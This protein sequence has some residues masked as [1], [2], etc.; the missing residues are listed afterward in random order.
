MALAKVNPDV[1]ALATAA[2]RE[3]VFGQVLIQGNATAFEMRHI[4]DRGAPPGGLR[5]VSENEMRGLA[6]FTSAGA[7]RPL[8]SAP[9]L[10]TGWRM[11]AKDERALGAALNHLY[12]GGVADWHAAQCGNPPVTSYRDFTARQTG[13]YRITTFLNDA[14]AAR[15]M[16]ACCHI[17]FCLKRRL[18]TVDGEPCDG[19]SAKSAIP[20]LEPCAVL[21][22][23]ARK[24]ARWEQQGT[25]PDAEPVEP[26][27]GS[28]KAECNFD[29]P[30]NPRR[31]RYFG[32][33]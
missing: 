27:A 32:K 20:C 12:P 30:Q 31:L 16:R 21:L 18:W 2:R 4:A 3:L 26:S 15:M 19:A 10:R 5:L 24:T 6:Q 1:A 9:N 22:E 29:D 33:G 7:F 14:T 28:G 8:K 11:V 13:M 23:F 25:E 17:D